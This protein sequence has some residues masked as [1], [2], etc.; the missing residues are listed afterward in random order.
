MATDYA[1]KTNAELIEILKSRDLPHTGKKAEMVARLQEDDSSKPAA[2]AQ[3]NADDV[4]DWE[5]DEVPAADAST[6][7]ADTETETATAPA[8]PAPAEEDIKAKA[9]ESKTGAEAQAEP[10]QET[11]ETGTVVPSGAEE[12]AAQQPA[13][14]KPAP[15]FSIGLSVTDLEEELKKRKARA[16]KFGITEDS[17]AAIDDAEKKL[18]RAKRFG[19]AG[20]EAP[21]AESVS[22]LDQALPEKSRKRGRGENDQGGRGGKRR[23]QNGRNNNQRQRGRGNRGQG[24]GQG[25][26]QG[27]AQKPAA[28]TSTSNGWSDKDK[29]AMEARKKRFAGGA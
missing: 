25:Q 8:P 15:N 17:Q 4:I 29:A 19:T 27:Q 21:S 14:E 5:D 9:E 26:K 2:P 24:Q 1:K 10:A 23:N 28:A 7:P 3:E 6:K 16:E 22:R 18:E 12:Q 11:A 20:E 13:E